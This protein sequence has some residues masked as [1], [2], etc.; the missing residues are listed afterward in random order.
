[1]SESRPIAVCWGPAST[2]H[3]FSCR[4]MH[5]CR[6]IGLCCCLPVI[7]EGAAWLS[8]SST[9]RSCPVLP[10]GPDELRGHLTPCLDAHS[11]PPSP[12]RCPAVLSRTELMSYEDSI[13][14]TVVTAIT[15]L[16]R[17]G[18]GCT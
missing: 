10:H 1:M 13:F 8:M 18:T 14:Y 17:W 2:P 7:A 9:A 12:L 6:V 11:C 15:T 3:I 4:N 16:D 5:D